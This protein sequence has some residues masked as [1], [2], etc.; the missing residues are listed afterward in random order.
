MKR[1]QRLRPRFL[2]SI[3][4]FF[5]NGDQAGANCVVAG[6]SIFKAPDRK[7]TIANMKAAIQC[8]C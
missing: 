4:S 5:F 7:K 8:H 3:K 1:L 6:S 2:F